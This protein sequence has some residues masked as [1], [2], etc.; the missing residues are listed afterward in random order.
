MMAPTIRPMLMRRHDSGTQMVILWYTW[1]PETTERHVHVIDLPEFIHPWY[2]Y[3]FYSPILANEA[4]SI[5]RVISN[6]I[7]ILA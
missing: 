4:S 5:H 7:C 6:G 3:Y 1:K 2:F